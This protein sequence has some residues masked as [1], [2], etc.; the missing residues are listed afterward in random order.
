M[1]YHMNKDIRRKLH[2]IYLHMK[3]RCYDPSDRR[4]ADWGGRGIH[5]CDEWLNNKEDFFEWSIQNGYKEGLSIDRIDNDKD[6]SP[7]NCRWVTLKEN[8]QNRRSSI[9]YT[10][11]GETKNLQQWCNEYGVSRS[12]VNRRL[13]L[14]WNILEALTKPKRTRD[15]DTLIGKKY[16]RL[17]VLEFSH[18]NKN[19]K[20][21]YKCLCECG[22]YTVVDDQKLKS[23]HTSSCG[24]VRK[25]MYESNRQK[26]K[27]RW[28][29]KN[30]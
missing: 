27:Q 8:N 14:G 20:S 24:C 23:G 19:R 2:K 4:Y 11:N 28:A 12:M 30:S 29:D 13:S 18:T 5:I 26:F 15:K 25:E 21:F 7:E 6:Y 16:G 22:N 10:I 3:E 9:F 1:L 17:T